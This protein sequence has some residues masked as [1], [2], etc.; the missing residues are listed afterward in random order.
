MDSVLCSKRVVHLYSF[1]EG[2]AFSQHPGKCYF[3]LASYTRWYRQEKVN[4]LLLDE[5]GRVGF[6]NDVLMH[7][8]KVLL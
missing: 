8:D 3:V 6:I 7:D 1:T 5:N 2:R 4:L